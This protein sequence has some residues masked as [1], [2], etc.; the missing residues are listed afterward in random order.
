M[1]AREVDWLTVRSH[2]ARNL[3]NDLFEKDMNIMSDHVISLDG[4]FLFVNINQG[5]I[6][7]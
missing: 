2:V 7:Y 1:Q 3:Y 5:L 4:W 6:D